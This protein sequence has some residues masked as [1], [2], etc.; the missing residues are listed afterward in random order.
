MILK[1]H[2]NATFHHKSGKVEVRTKTL[3][4]GTGSGT[5][6]CIRMPEW[7]GPSRGMYGGTACETQSA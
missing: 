6:V 1:M 4:W 2:E 5:S 7:R 3:F